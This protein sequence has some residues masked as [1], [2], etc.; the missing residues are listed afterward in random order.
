MNRRR[1]EGQYRAIDLALFA[2]MTILFEA[3]AVFAARVWF[4][5]QPYTVSVVALLTAIVMMRWGPFAAIHAVLGGLVYC[6]L[7]GGGGRSFLVW[8]AGNLLGLGALAL[9]KLWGPEA[10]RQSVFRT[11]LFG[12]V[13]LLLMQGGRALT[14]LL[15]GASPG[16]AAAFFTTDVITMLFTLVILWMV[17]RLDG[18]FEDQRHYLLRVQEEQEKE[19]GGFR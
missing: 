2:A 1:S 12:A 14:A 17:R 5:G 9:R 6:W 3:I 8:G 18:V 16:E 11:L 19:R 13:T 15:L 10:I 7:S 4:P